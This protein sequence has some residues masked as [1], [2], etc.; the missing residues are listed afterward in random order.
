[1]FRPYS[2]RF[3]VMIV[4]ILTHK[5]LAIFLKLQCKDVINFNIQY[6]SINIPFLTNYVAFAMDHEFE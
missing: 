5:I 3:H 4:D 1:M 6:F 2:S